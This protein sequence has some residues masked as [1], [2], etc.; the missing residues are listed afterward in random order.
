MVIGVVL[1]LWFL[2]GVKFFSLI[3]LSLAL[4][5]IGLLGDLFA[6]MLKRQAQVKDASSLLPG[7]GGMLDRL[8]SLIFAAPAL[9]YA[10]LFIFQI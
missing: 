4:G 10:R 2:P 1:G 3:L 8:D 7:H 6:S 9:L 5:F